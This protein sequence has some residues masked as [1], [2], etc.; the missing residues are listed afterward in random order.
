MTLPKVDSV[1]KQL[2]ATKHFTSLICASFPAQVS[3]AGNKE[4]I[5]SWR[6]NLADLD[7][8]ASLT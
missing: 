2:A 5:S 1:T 8:I 7:L 6:K 4:T 3:M